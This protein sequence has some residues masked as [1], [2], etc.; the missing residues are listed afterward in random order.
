[1][2]AATQ[3]PDWW[4]GAVTY[5]VYP[6][7]F[8]DTTG[9]G[10]GDLPG[11]IDRLPYIAGLGVDA[12]WI[13]PFFKSPMADFGYD[14]ADYRA[15]DPMFGTND[16][17]HRLIAEAHRL[18]LRVMFDMVLCHSSDQHPW[19]QESRRARTGDKADWYVW[20]DPKPDGSPPNNWVSVF[21]GGAWEWDAGREQYYLH[22]FLASQ[23]AL[24]WNNPAV[25]AAMFDECRFWFDA[26]VDGLRL[27]AITTL[28]CDPELRDNPPAG[29][30][31]AIDFGGDGNNPFLHQKHL[32][33]RDVPHTLAILK[34]LRQLTDGYPGRVL[35]G[36]IGDVDSVAVTA[37]YSRTTEA[38]HTCYTF[39]MLGA[40]P[41]AAR[42][43]D[44]I[45]RFES[46]M[47]EGCPT[48]ALGNHDVAR[49]L[50]RWNR[51]DHLAGDDRA[52]AKLILAFLFSIRGSIC[53]YQGEELGLSNVDIPFERMV[54]PFGL[55]FY[56]EYKGRDG[57]RTPM[58]WRHDAPGLGFTTGDPWLPIGPDHGDLAVDR[59]DSRV[60][61]D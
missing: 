34:Q 42:L 44:I 32:Y 54:D 24:N 48:Y 36:E 6:R 10:V 1:M 9:N 58:P 8:L 3:N 31:D 43:R 2:T 12:L 45:Q 27:D 13:S 52:L 35:L 61:D 51:F 4:R 46:A 56:P 25:A 22:H 50:T 40:D 20:A 5:Q 7:S 53:L 47:G 30:E 28:A 11:I 18:G 19:F 57:C 15:V 38:L 60:D 29:P 39:Q 23:P 41:T 37:K 26:G 14:V 21:G 49:C 17:A 55:A 33:D 16:D 59:Q